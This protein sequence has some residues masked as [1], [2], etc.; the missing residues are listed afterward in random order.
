MGTTFS[1]WTAVVA[2]AMAGLLL[3]LVLLRYDT[4]RN[5]PGWSLGYATRRALLLA[6]VIPLGVVVVLLVPLWLG[7]VLLAV[8]ALIILVMALAS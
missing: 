5:R 7:A 1:G 6:P 4:Y 3:V 2:V 8:P